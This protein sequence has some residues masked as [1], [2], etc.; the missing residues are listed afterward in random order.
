MLPICN[1]KFSY[2][3]LITFLFKIN[4]KQFLYPRAPM[5]HLHNI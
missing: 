1:T 3:Q 4:S 5:L 2:L